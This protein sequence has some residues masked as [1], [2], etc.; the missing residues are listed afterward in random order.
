[1]RIAFISDLHANI[2]ALQAVLA[3]ARQRSVDQVICL[4]DIVDMGPAP[5]EVVD[6]LR[7]E[8]VFCIQGNHDTLNENPGLDFLKDIEAWTARVLSPE[9]KQWLA[10]LPFSRLLEMDQHRVLC[11]HGS[12]DKNTQGLVSETPAEKLNG[13]LE[14][15]GVDLLIA[16]HTHVPMQRY[17]SKGLVVNV[18]S[19]SSPF[20]EAFVV[21]PTI[22]KYSD[23]GIVES[24]AGALSVEL[25]RLPLD[26]V[27]LAHSIR[28]AG[29][30]H[31]EVLLDGYID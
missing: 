18:G 21:P 4:G 1:M 6:L 13:W 14:D 16:G 22:L 24:R 8:K 5:G 17:V 3:D 9:Q 19:T 23:Y 29:M 12:P 30:P 10:D 2:D 31:G 15:A 20:A 26:T 7:A 28:E 11:V 27:K 25:I